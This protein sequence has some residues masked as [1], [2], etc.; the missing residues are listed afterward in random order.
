MKKNNMA[1]DKIKKKLFFWG[2]KD[3]KKQ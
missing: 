2:Q 3:H 1:I